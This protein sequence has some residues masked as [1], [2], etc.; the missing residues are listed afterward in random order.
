MGIDQIEVPEKQR[1]YGY[2]GNN[3]TIRTP[4]VSQLAEE[5]LV[6]QNWYSGYHICSPSRAAMVTGRLPIRSGCAPAVFYAATSGGLPDN[7][8]TIAEAL[9]PMGYRSMI[10]GKS[11]YRSTPVNL[12]PRLVTT[13]LSDRP[14]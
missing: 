11:V 14:R 2:T 8:T 12:H 5:G 6:F 1:A 9:K 4:H 3:H 10:I 13:C 7:E